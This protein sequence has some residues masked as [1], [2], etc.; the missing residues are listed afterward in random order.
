MEKT[1]DVY[2]DDLIRKLLTKEQEKRISWNDYFK[3]PFFTSYNKDN[4][5]EKT[6]DIKNG[7]IIRVKIRKK[8]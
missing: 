6:I 8:N 3:H 4:Q 7:I 1:Q 5:N 2:L